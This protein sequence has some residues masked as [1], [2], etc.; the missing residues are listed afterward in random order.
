MFVILFISIVYAT[1]FDE[2]VKQHNKHYTPTESIKRRAIFE[3]NGKF[4]K[5]FNKHHSFKLSLDGPFAAMTN[6]EYNKLLG[7][8]DVNSQNIHVEHQHI[9]SIPDSVDW[10]AQGKVTSIKDQAQCGS[11]YAFSSI[12]SIESNYLIA[13]NTKFTVNNLD[14][15]EQQVVDCSTKNNGCNGGSLLYVMQYVKKEGLMQEK[16]Y[17]YTGTVGTC[18]YDETKVVIANSGETTIQQRS[19][20]DLTEALASNVVAVAIDASHA[21]FQLYKSGIYD[22]PKCKEL[23]LD[24]GVTAVGYGSENGQDYYIV[25]NSWGTS[26]GEDGYIRMSRNKNNQCGIASGA[27]YPTGVHDM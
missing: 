5:K 10:R 9:K 16:D 15:S 4:V 7:K 18:K 11:C 26:W 25:K 1:H 19:E 24:H 23:I 2:W 3:M 27:V 22:E 6:E 12:A 14:L 8:F 17:S 21:S 13:G 20:K